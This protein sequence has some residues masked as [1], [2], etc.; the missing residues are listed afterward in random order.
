LG[1]F[2]V[3]LPLDLSGV[4]VEIAAAFDDCIELNAGLAMESSASARLN[5]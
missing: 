5:R 2:T 3:R 1:D 4:E